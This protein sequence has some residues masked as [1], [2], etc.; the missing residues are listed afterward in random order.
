MSAMFLTV[1]FV[2]MMAFMARDLPGVLLA[3]MILSYVAAMV[4][5]LWVSSTDPG[6]VPRRTTPL[7]EL[8]QR[9]S[10]DIPGRSGAVLTYCYT[11]NVYRGPRTHHCGVCN[12]C[13]DQFDHHCPWTGTCIGARNYRAFWIFLSTLNVLFVVSFI[14]VVVAPLRRSE[15]EGT[16]VLAALRAEAFMPIVLAIVTFMLGNTISGLLIFHAY[17]VWNGLTTAEHLKE[18][19]AKGNPW[20]E[21]PQ[22]NCGALCCCRVN[23]WVYSYNY[24]N[25][26]VQV[27][28]DVYGNVPSANVVAP[29]RLDPESSANVPSH[30]VVLSVHSPPEGSLR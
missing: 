22:G 30:D 7:D 12:N 10:V 3:V 23:A 9:V 15:A 16:T 1:P 24:R 28:H 14:C 4:S 26:L 29:P 8:D 18:T 19:W 2:L 11:C 17:L 21:G 20:D 6:I 27:Y 13:V 5:L 25:V